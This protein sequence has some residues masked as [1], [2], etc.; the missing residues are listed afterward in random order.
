MK[1]VT[2]ALPVAVLGVLSACA[3]TSP[4][5]PSG[6]SS[7]SSS[8]STASVAAPS[9]SIQSVLGK[10][11]SSLTTAVN[12]TNSQSQGKSLTAAGLA[13]HSILIE[14]RTV[15]TCNTAGCRVFEQFE[16][17]FGC[18]D[19]GYSSITSQLDGV[20]NA[21][22][23]VSGTLN[24]TSYSSFVDCSEGGWVT[25]SDPY[26]TGGGTIRINDTR[27]TMNIT[28]GGGLVMTN[29]PGTPRG[30]S[31]CHFSGVLFQWDTL[32]GWSNSGSV[33]CQPGGTFK[34]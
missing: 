6:S 9:A 11:S 12:A 3:G 23:V 5:S 18:G 20:L 16:R 1:I 24:W 30:R 27:M 25:N 14:P 33:V 21:G 13:G 8:S 34:Y 31:D 17:R 10:V 28:M 7:S 15:A 29:A 2:I 4:T 22:N 19:G 32:T 26:L